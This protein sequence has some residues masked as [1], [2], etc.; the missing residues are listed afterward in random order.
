MRETQNQI[1]NVQKQKEKNK[2][3]SVSSALDKEVTRNLV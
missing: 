3:Q 1:M 2:E